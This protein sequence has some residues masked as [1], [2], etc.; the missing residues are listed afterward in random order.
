MNAGLRWLFDRSNIGVAC[1]DL[2]EMEH[3]FR[4]SMIDWTA[5]RPVR[6]VGGSGWP[7]CEVNY[8][9][10]SNR[11]A[12]ADVARYMLDLAEGIRVASTRTPTIAR[13]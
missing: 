12:R 11:I 13:G 4:G 7:T 8:F 2:A 10:L 6:L 1:R 9:G 3:V 5:V